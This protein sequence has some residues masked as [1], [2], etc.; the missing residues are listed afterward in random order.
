MAKN[1][2]EVV[3]SVGLD[4]SKQKFGINLNVSVGTD[5]NSHLKNLSASTSRP[6]SSIVR[7]TLYK[8]FLNKEVE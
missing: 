3:N 8:I 7:K 5:L 4:F 1:G 6:V 2:K